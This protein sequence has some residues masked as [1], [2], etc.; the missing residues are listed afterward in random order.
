M[1][2]GIIRAGCGAVRCVE[3]F[4]MTHVNAA[5]VATHSQRHTQQSPD[6]ECGSAK[7]TRA[8]Y[9]VKRAEHGDNHRVNE[10]SVSKDARGDLNVQLRGGA[11]NGEFAYIGRV[12][13]DVV[14]Y[15]SGKLNEGELLLEVENLSISGLPL[16]DIHT[17]IKNCKGP[18]RLKTVRQ[19][20]S[21]IK[22]LQLLRSIFL[23]EL[24]RIT[25]LL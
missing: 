7:S 18:V 15:Q 13:E 22:E 5:R 2:K 16:Y 19:G 3:S 25:E 20:Q 10:T 6:W 23:S 14:V 24:R 4:T 9:L 8:S 17:V 12:E 21:E 11:E 1:S